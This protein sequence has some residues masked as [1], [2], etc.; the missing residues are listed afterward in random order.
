MP[1]NQS[2]DPDTAHFNNWPN[3]QGFDGNH[4]QKTPVE[5]TVTGHIPSYAAGLLYRTGPGRYKVDTEKGNTFQVSHWFDGFSQTHR[6]QLIPPPPASPGSGMRVLYNSRFS[7]DELIEHACTTG[8][9]A[10]NF[11]FSG[12]R[13][14]CKALYQKAQVTYEPLNGGPSSKNIGV[15]L[16]V[17]FPGMPPASEPTGKQEPNAGSQPANAIKTLHAKT[18]NSSFKQLDPETLEPIGLADQTALHPDLNGPLSASHAKADPETGDIYNYNLSFAPI[19]TYRVFHVSATTGETT[20]LATF[21]GTP[22]YLHSFFLTKNYVIICVWN[23]HLSP[24]G[25]AKGSYMAALR[26]FDDSLPAKW[27]VVDRRHG[28]GLVAT[29]ESP[30][31]FCFHIINAWEEMKTNP[32][33]QSQSQIDIVAECAAYKNTDI[34]KRLYYEYLSSNSPAAHPAVEARNNGGRTQS[35]IARHRLPGLAIPTGSPLSAPA[36]STATAVASS[37]KESPA[38]PV[39]V[40]VPAPGPTAVSHPPTRTAMLES[41]SC[42]HLSPDLPI[43]NPFYITRPHRYTY[44][45]IDRGLSTFV[46]GL[47]KFDSLTSEVKI[48][49]EHAQSP[50]EAIFVPDPEGEDEDDGVLLSVVLDGF[51]GNS[52]LLVLDAR[53]MKEVGRAS[54][55]GVV[56]FG[57][58]GLHVSTTGVGRAGGRDF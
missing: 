29:Y 21:P 15:T 16:S 19:P 24:E 7:T 53:G 54:V 17:N 37:S 10:G 1:E 41:T 14:P 28:N 31:F 55:H 51:S 50:G 22:S 2:T 40:P 38:V 4:E 13:D 42:S 18:D 11:S 47:M 23:A 43:L 52:Y 39:P 46:D 20:I 56:A 26:E 25:F 3:N 9:L 5:L 6:F 57:F 48:W 12:V 35:Q 44:A 49:S 32:D 34:L 36:I 58:H 8:S 45:P 27:Y 33:D 30:A